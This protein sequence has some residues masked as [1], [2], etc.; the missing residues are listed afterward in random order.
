MMTE[1]SEIIAKAAAWMQARA[2]KAELAKERGGVHPE[3]GRA[4]QSPF[5]HGVIEVDVIHE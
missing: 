5:E 4:E 2:W 1:S 3:R